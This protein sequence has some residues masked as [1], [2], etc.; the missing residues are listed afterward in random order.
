MSTDSSAKSHTIKR[1]NVN[2]FT[3]DTASNKPTSVPGSNTPINP[4]V[5]LVD[6]MRQINTN[7]PDAQLNK[8]SMSDNNGG[9]ITFNEDLK[10]SNVIRGKE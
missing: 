3:N 2:N 9:R 8:D 10:C 4:L 6:S 5:S 1:E 7:R